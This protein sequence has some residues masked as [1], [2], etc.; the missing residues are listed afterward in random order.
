VA[1]LRRGRVLGQELQDVRVVLAAPDAASADHV[2][3]AGQHVAGAAAEAAATRLPGPTGGQHLEGA[4][5]EQVSPP[6][7]NYS[8]HDAAAVPTVKTRLSMCISFSLFMMWT[9]RQDRKLLFLSRAPAAS[10]STF[11]YVCLGSSRTHAAA[12]RLRD[13]T[14]WFTCSTPGSRGGLGGRS[15]GGE[16]QQAHPH[17]APPPGCSSAVLPQR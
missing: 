13:A 11:R 5:P 14:C 17:R 16:Q 6:P 2:H 8:S 12:P 15:E 9:T 10:A 7:E 4:E 3:D 1:L